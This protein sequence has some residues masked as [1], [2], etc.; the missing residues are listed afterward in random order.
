MRIGLDVGGTHTDAVLVGNKGIATTAKVLT[1]HDDLLKSVL[2]ALREVLKGTDPQGIKGITLST[3]LTTNALLEGKADRVGVLVSSGPGIAPDNYRIGDAYFIVDGVIDHRGQER[4]AL[5]KRQLEDAVAT[6]RNQGIRAFAVASKF[7]TRN[8][9]HELIMESAIGRDADF[10]TA[11]H[12]LSG[13]LNFPRRITTSCFNSA[14]WR[15]YNEFA[16]AVEK[17]IADLGLDA[18]I[19][20]LKADGGTMPLSAS[21][22]MPV[23]SILSGPAASIMGIAALCNIDRDTVVLD[24]GGTSTD[25][26]IFAAGSPLIEQEGI[27]LHGRATLV[28]SLRTASI[29]IGGDSALRVIDG[30]ITVGPDRIGPAMAAGGKNPALIDA[31]NV[32]GEAVFGDTSASIRGI[33]DLALKSGTSPDE[34]ANKAVMIAAAAISSAV[35]QMISEV[36]ERPVYTIHELLHSEGIAP[37]QLFIIGGPADAF[38]RRLSA[39]L[40][41]VAKV[42][43]LHSVANAVGSALTRTTMDLELFADTERDVLLV[44]ALSIKKFIDQNYSLEDAQSDARNYLHASAAALE[45]DSAAQVQIIGASSFNMISDSRTAGRNIRVRCQIKPGH[46]ASYLDAVRSA[47]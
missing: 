46:I 16:V 29:A 43:A 21:R 39:T 44:P 33:S 12:R 37:S 10:I 28:R 19:N 42:P 2:A 35:Q 24:I 22:N 32:A 15:K 4:K 34:F 47:C 1:D 3:T 17:G 45:S 25:I 18:P 31:L 14:V 38:S 7:S 41:I 9:D 30:N 26:A 27:S 23:Q 11:G 6:C 40:G 20:V 5:D 8:P 13:S 36:N